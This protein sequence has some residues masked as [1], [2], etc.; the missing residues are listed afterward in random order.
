ME[1]GFAAGSQPS[2]ITTFTEVTTAAMKITLHEYAASTS[3]KIL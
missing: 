1:R 2:F 3:S